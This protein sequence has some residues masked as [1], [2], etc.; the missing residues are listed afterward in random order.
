MSSEYIKLLEEENRALRKR[1]EYLENTL[2]EIETLTYRSKKFRVISVEDTGPDD[3]SCSNSNANNGIQSDL[4]ETIELNDDDE[5]VA[6]IGAQS[7]VLSYL[8]L[9]RRTSDQQIA[10]V[11][12]CS[13]AERNAVTTNREI[14]SAHTK[15][16]LNK[17]KHLRI[18]LNRLSKRDISKLQKARPTTRSTV[19]SKATN[20][21]SKNIKKGKKLK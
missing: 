21:N 4:L 7:D 13:R 17:C 12:V 8:Q 15:K 14:L 1:V 16:M 10:N 19:K 3:Q 6:T 20:D 11:P 18:S 5:P 2:I 9:Q